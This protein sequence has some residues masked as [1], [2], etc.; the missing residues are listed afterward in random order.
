MDSYSETE[1]AIAGAGPAGLAC[2]LKLATAG[3]NV[4][5]TDK[6]TF[7]RSKPCG[8]GLGVRSLRVLS[9]LGIDLEEF[10]HKTAITGVKIHTPAHHTHTFSTRHQEG[11][12]QP[13]GYVVDRSEFDHFLLQKV[14]S[15][16][17]VTFL[18]AHKVKMIAGHGDQVVIAG[19]GFRI[20]SNW[21]VDARGARYADHE[22]DRKNWAFALTGTVG[23]VDFEEQ[24]QNIIEFFFMEPL[25][26]GYF[27]IF[28]LPHGMANTG[29]YVPL[30]HYKHNLTHIKEM[31]FDFIQNHQ[32]LAGRFQEAG[33]EDSLQGGWLPLGKDISE[34]VN[35]H[36]IKI[37]DAASLVDPL[38]GEGIGNALLS[39]VIAAETLIKVKKGELDSLN[40]YE[41]DLKRVMEGEFRYRQLMLRMA[42]RYP[43]AFSYLFQR[44]S[45]SKHLRQMA[46]SAVKSN[47]FAKNISPTQLLRSLLH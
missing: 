20:I 26:P 18:P 30:T 16:Q 36:I 39:G 22:Q 45:Q 32:Q 15:Q 38:A 34:T 12:D 35:G 11:L 31:Y 33:L 27:W 23:G 29:I 21:A 42:A 3:I 14:L 4:M 2:A 47:D 44:L 40:T 24:E 6:E 25:F 7:P 9:D 43:K 8:G 41:T 19:D 46:S 28:P 1:V 37:G 5:L 17:G 13:L 10:E